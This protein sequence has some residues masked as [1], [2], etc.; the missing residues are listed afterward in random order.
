VYHLNK[1]LGICQYQILL[2]FQALFLPA[3]LLFVQGMLEW[4]WPGAGL[5]RDL[6]GR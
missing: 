5:P 4:I 6:S 2:F 3:I 1:S